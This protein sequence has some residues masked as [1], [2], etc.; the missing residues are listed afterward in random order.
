VSRILHEVLDGLPKEDFYLVG[1]EHNLPITGVES[2]EVS[3][4]SQKLSVLVTYQDD[5]RAG[6]LLW[7]SC[8]HYPTGSA[9][10]DLLDY[11]ELSRPISALR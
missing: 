4:E 10:Y 7:I 1:A 5:V 6:G 8:W 9:G 3:D 2:A 11:E